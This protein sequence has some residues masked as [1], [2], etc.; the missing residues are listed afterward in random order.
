M[1]P[2]YEVA[3][4]PRTMAKSGNVTVMVG[5]TKSCSVTVVAQG[6][7]LYPA[8]SY[9]KN[10]L[11]SPPLPFLPLPSTP[12]LS[13]PSLAPPP[14][15]GSAAPPPPSPSPPAM[16]LT[17]P[18]IVVQSV[19]NSYEVVEAGGVGGG[20]RYLVADVVATQGQGDYRDWSNLMPGGVG[21]WAEGG[22]AMGDEIG[23]AHV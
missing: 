1:A 3:L 22:R 20:V 19:L 21:G 7:A 2:H 12:F 8:R 13:L 14:P 5:M 11:P 15:P 18:S 9:K 23:R 17:G 16:V 10:V 4:W 6:V